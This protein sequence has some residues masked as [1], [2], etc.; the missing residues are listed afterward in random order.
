MAVFVADRDASS[1]VVALV[2]GVKRTGE[3][4]GRGAGVGVGEL[5]GLH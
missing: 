4:R 2:V 3:S 1:S 5:Q